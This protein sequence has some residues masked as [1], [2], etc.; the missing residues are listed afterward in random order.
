MAKRQR[1]RPLRRKSPQAKTSPRPGRRGAENTPGLRAPITVDVPPHGLSERD[2]FGIGYVHNER[3]PDRRT[4]WPAD[5]G[6]PLPR[7]AVRDVN[8]LALRNDEGE[9]VPRQ[10]R[11][12]ATWPDGSVMFAHVAWQC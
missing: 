9:L 4:N 3:L 8:Q 2:F 11:P 7:G 1:H 10:V 6:F 12:L 5:R